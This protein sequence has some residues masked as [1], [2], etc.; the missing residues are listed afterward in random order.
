MEGAES[1]AE[2]RIMNHETL[3]T[4]EENITPL[5]FDKFCGK[6]RRRGKIYALMI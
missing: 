1:R 3:R 2:C 6:K 5:P 4:C